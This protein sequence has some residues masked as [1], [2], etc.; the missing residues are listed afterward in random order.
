[1]EVQHQFTHRTHRRA[2]LEH[3]RDVVGMPRSDGVAQIKLVNAK[4]GQPRAGLA[5]RL[6]R[7]GAV[8]RARDHAAHIAAHGRARCMRPRDHGTEPLDRLCDRRVDVPARKPLACRREHAHLACAAGK[9]ALEALLVG[10]EHREERVRMRPD[11]RRQHL[12]GVCELRH[13]LRTHETRRLDLAK[14]RLREQPD[15][16]ELVV[17]R[18][19]PLLVLKAIAGPDLAQFDELGAHPSVPFRELPLRSCSSCSRCSRL[20]TR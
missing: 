5:H 10:N 1:M 20:A 2:R 14:A 17:R 4:R 3:S 18:H 9:G 19:E 6:G 11:R 13:P 8:V 7:D 16:A 15:V 12:L